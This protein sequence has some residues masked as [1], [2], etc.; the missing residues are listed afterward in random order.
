MPTPIWN[1]I[2]DRY[3]GLRVY[4]KIPEV[5][6]FFD[7]VVGLGSSLFFLNKPTDRKTNKSDITTM[8][9]PKS[10]DR[11]I[12]KKLGRLYNWNT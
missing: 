10:L 7:I 9:N 1:I 6:S 4:L 11:N 12:F 3:I 5:I 2:K 8:I